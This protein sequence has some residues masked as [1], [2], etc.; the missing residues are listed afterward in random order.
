MVPPTPVAGAELEAFQKSYA[1]H[2]LNTAGWSGN[3]HQEAHSPDLL[4]PIT[5]D[6]NLAYR[7]PASLEMSYTAPLVGQVWILKDEVGQKFPGRSPQVAAEPM[8][9]S[10]LEFFRQ[11]PTAWL[12]DFTQTAQRDHDVMR[13]QLAVKPS[14]AAGQPSRI[15]VEV[16]AL[17]FDPLRLEIVFAE[18]TSLVF[19]FSD[20]KSLGPAS[21]IPL[22]P[23]THESP[24]PSPRPGFPSHR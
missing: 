1:D 21:A 3:F 2:R 7:A 24:P 10:L 8:V 14:A 18:K 13:I 11:P 19:I 6:G 15:L 16:N 22:E 5:S 12:K 9:R 23:P 17:T 20:W 4:M